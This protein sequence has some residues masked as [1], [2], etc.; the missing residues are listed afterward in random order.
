MS[1]CTGYTVEANKIES[2]GIKNIFGI[3]IRHSW[4]APNE[5]YR[6]AVVNCEVGVQA[7][8]VNRSVNGTTGLKILCNNLSEVYRSGIHV[9]PSGP[10]IPGIAKHQM[11]ITSGQQL[12]LIASAANTFSNGSPLTR[13]FE[14]YSNNIAYSQIIYRYKPLAAGQKPINTNLLAA[15]IIATSINSTCPAKATGAKPTPFPFSLFA[16]NNAAIEKQIREVKTDAIASTDSSEILSF[17]YTE[18]AKLIDSII[19]YYQYMS[20][21]DSTGN[22]NYTD[23]IAHVYQQ[24]STNYEYQLYLA[25]AY[26]ELGRYADAIALLGSLSAH[27]NLSVEESQQVANMA[28]MY[29][30]MQWLQQN[31]GDWAGLSPAMK[32]LVYGYEQGDDMFAGAIARS[33]LAQYE[34][35]SYDP[36]Y[37]APEELTMPINAKVNLNIATNIYPNPA[38]DH[39]LVNYTGDNAVLSL[40]DMTGKEVLRQSLNSNRTTIN[41]GKLPAG[42]YYAAIWS[43]ATIQYQQKIVKK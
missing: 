13:D 32:D 14:V 23:S 28:D 41:I 31:N 20:Y 9:V 26:M 27:Y 11:N 7:A 25:S 10:M 42:M 12:S 30:V 37:I 21:Y 2:V 8:G 6:N 19:N 1:N 33:L 5:V 29:Q 43:G 35:R 17:L 24:V 38:T 39:L 15:N 40:T 22:G 4:T 36:I 34:G 16:T 18:Q 3:I